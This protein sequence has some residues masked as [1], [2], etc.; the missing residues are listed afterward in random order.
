MTE[1]GHNAISGPGFHADSWGAGPFVIHAEGKSFR[2][3]D[4]DRFGPY[5]ADRHGDPLRNEYPPTRSPFWRAHRIWVRQGR[6]LAEDRISKRSAVVVDGGDEDGKT[7][8]V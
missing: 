7:I 1:F 4:S 8:E 5:L 6:C 3:G 2:F